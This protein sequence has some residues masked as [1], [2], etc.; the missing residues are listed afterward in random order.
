MSAKNPDHALIQMQQDMV[1]LVQGRVDQTA[2]TTAAATK[3]APKKPKAPKGAKKPAPKKAAGGAN[4]KGGANRQKYLGTL[5]KETIS[6]GLASLPDDVAESVLEMIKNDKPDVD[7]SADGT[8][9]LDIDMISPGTLWKIH[10]LI[11]KYAP[12]VEAEIKKSM[13]EKESPRT[14]AKP[15]PKKKNKPMSKTE[16]ERKI[17]QLRNSMQEFERHNS[18]SQEPVLPTVEQAESSGDEDSDDSEEE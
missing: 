17:E 10:A 3:K 7:T 14:L 16:Q 13:M 4:K 6:A 8:L 11:L 5:E 9:E 18:G 2:K 12:E 15:A 1:A